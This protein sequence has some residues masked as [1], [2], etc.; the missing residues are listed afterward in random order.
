MNDIRCLSCS[1][2][3]GTK[4]SLTTRTEGT[5]MAVI[6]YLCDICIMPWTSALVDNF[7]DRSFVRKISVIENNQEI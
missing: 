6:N 1:E 2:P 3:C 7:R 4:N 5:G